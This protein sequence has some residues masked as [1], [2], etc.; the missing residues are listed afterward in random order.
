MP[1]QE[2]KKAVNPGLVEPQHKE[3]MQRKQLNLL[4]KGVPPAIQGSLN[5]N[6]LGK[7]FGYSIMMS[8]KIERARSYPFCQNSDNALV[9]IKDK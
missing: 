7:L 9:G 6:M 3:T 4:G 5:T 1:S 2:T 8:L